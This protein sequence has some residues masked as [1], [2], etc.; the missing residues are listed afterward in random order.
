MIARLPEFF[1]RRRGW[2]CLGAVAI[3]AALVLG[4]GGCSGE[5]DLWERYRAERQ[6]WRARRFLGLAGAGVSTTPAAAELRA[7]VA[8]EKVVSAFP[9]ERWATAE[10]LRRP[11]AQDVARLSGTAAL[12]RV[13]MDERAGRAEATERGYATCARAFAGVDSVAVAARAG[14]ARALE[15]LGRD[16]EAA[17]I[18]L[19]L[20]LRAAEPD[21]AGLAPWTV[22]LTAPAEAVRL[23]EHAGRRMA[24]DSVRARSA[25]HLETLARQLTGTRVAE[26]LWDAIAGMWRQGG[27]PDRARAAVRAAL[28]EPTGGDRRADR[29]LQLAT[30]SQEAREPDSARVYAAWAARE[31]AGPVAM[32]ATLTLAHAWADAGVAD[33]AL[34]VYKQLIEVL[35]PMGDLAARAR[36]DRAGLLDRIQ[37]WEAAR[38][39]LRALAMMQP[40]HPCGV[41]ALVEIVR[42]HVREGESLFA[43]VETKHALE[44]FDHLL[45]TQ[46]DPGVRLETMMARADVLS[47]MGQTDAA[48]REYTAAWREQQ[49]LPAAAV[50]GWRA[51]RLADSALSQPVVARELYTELAH[52]AADLEVRWRAR[53]HLANSTPAVNAP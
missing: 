28:A 44:T 45:A 37:H 23:L 2:R 51:A 27:D 30:L 13:G 34:A 7:A 40:T 36:L 16:E 14:H 50:A 47:L 6:L 24:A 32:E 25:A 18:W 1:A 38:A 3:V 22:R 33:S 42:H 49:L 31:F 5:H 15:R 4:A 46:G 29:V 8:L 41:A 12:L 10:A 35:P 9:P 19:E 26:D 43:T 11:G 39:E 53:Q 20:A 48:L 17:T 52:G 21:S